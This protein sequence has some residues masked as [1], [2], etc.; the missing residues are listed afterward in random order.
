MIRLIALDL[1]GTLLDPAFRVSPANTEAVRQARGRGVQVVLSTSRWYGLAQRTARRLELTTPLVCHNGAHVKEPEDGQEL[2]HLRI[3]TEAAKEI[4]AFCDAGG[5]ETMTTVDGI[6]YL[7]VPWE[8]QI[9]PQRLPEDMRV[10]RQQAQ[11]VT[12]PVTGILVFGE[13]ACRAVT[14]RF[15]E[16]FAAQITFPLSQSEGVQPYLAITHTEVDKGRALRLVCQRLEVP[17]DQVLA[18]GDSQHDVPMFEVAGVGVAMGNATV[19]VK[20]R[21]DAVAPTNAED[22]VAW[23]IQRFVLS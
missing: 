9:D 1:D 23:A 14:E 17:L 11:H 20:A 7:R 6:T 2:L 10:E 13:E 12:K 21:A 5:F 3:E 22:G 19:E 4:A 16:R 8:D 18:V 15:E